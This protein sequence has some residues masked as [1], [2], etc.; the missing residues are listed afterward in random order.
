[1]GYF[2]ETMA[3]FEFKSDIAYDYARKRELERR[4]GDH[5]KASYDRAKATTDLYKDF[6]QTPSR[7]MSDY[8]RRNDASKTGAEIADSVEKR[9]DINRKERKSCKESFSEAFDSVIL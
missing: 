4:S 9:R 2:T 5:D 1:M 8:K 7:N 3:L 6:V